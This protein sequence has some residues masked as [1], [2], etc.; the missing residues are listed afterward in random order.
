[1]MMKNSKPIFKNNFIYTIK[2]SILSCLKSQEL[3]LLSST[4]KLSN[5]SLNIARHITFPISPY[6]SQF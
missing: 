4:G 5:T 1:M 2:G 6:A 3:F